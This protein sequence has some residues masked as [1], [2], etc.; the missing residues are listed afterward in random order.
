MEQSA[1]EI[2]P[3]RSRLTKKES[4]ADEKIRRA[5]L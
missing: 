2:C 3:L 1:P 5:G 4:A